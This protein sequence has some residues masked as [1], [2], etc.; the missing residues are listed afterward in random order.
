[1][2][3]NDIVDSDLDRRCGKIPMLALTPEVL[4]KLERVF[5]EE[6]ECQCTAGAYCDYCEGVDDLRAAIAAARKESEK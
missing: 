1:M 3:L 4:A 5:D 2:G 6:E